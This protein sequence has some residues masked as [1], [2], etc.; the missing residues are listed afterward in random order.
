MFKNI[1]SNYSPPS[2]ERLFT[3]LLHEE[4]IQVDIKINNS[5]KNQKNLT[6]G[7]DYIL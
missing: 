6:L 1:R 3:N 4:A 2:R 5:L 7:M